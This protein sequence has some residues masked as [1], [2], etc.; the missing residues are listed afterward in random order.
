MWNQITNLAFCEMRVDL[1]F[2]CSL[3]HCEEGFSGAWESR[4]AGFVIGMASL[5][6][7]NLRRRRGGDDDDDD[8]AGEGYSYSR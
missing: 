6:E 7:G 5:R 2:C 3:S 8:G 1:N 4:A